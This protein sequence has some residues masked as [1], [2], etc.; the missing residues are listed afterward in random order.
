M[1]VFGWLPGRRTAAYKRAHAH[2]KALAGLEFSLAQLSHDLHGLAELSQANDQDDAAAVS[3]GAAIAS[4]LHEVIASGERFAAALA[5][6]EAVGAWRELVASIDR[7]RLLEKGPNRVAKL[8]VAATECEQLQQFVSQE[9]A[10][11]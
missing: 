7:A 9:L 5:N 8:K 1:G 10:A 3:R 4:H 6:D 2:R 11:L